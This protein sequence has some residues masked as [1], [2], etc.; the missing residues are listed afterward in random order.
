LDGVTWTL[1]IEVQ[2]YLLAPL[3]AHVFQMT[4][5]PRRLALVAAMCGAPLLANIV[6]RGSLTVLEFA[7][8]FLGGFLLADLYTSGDQAR[9]VPVWGYDLLATVC[10]MATFLVPESPLLPWVLPWLLCGIFLGALRGGWFARFL[11]RPWV[12]VLGGM[13]YS[14]YLLHNPILSFLAG[15]LIASGISLPHAFLK[16]GI[17]GLPVV[18][19]AG[20]AYYILIE[21]PCMNPR[22]PQQVWQSALRWGGAAAGKIEPRAKSRRQ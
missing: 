12:S 5:R 4:A 20:M 16:L 21:R 18:V 14:L 10:L 13:C 11:K 6:P 7:Q 1:E 9:G 22:W 17:V 8:Y 3:L 19:G 15:R 2:F